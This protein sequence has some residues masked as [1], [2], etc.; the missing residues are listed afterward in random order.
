MNFDKLI[1]QFGI[2]LSTYIVCLASGFLPFVNA[3]VFLVLVS[4]I[5]PRHRAPFVVLIA[6]FG[7]MTAKAIIYLAGRGALKLPLKKYE[8]KLD[9]IIQKYGKKRIASNLFIFLSAFTGLPP[10]YIIS[11]LAGVIKF[12]FMSFLLYGFLGRLIRFSLV[13]FFPQLFKEIFK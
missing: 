1:V 3:E 5:T 10:F 13:V 4:A 8:Q 7:Q 12:K 9:T 6:T 11:I 2:Y